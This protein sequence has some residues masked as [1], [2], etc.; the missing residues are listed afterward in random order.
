MYDLL[1]F[2]VWKPCVDDTKIE[3]LRKLEQLIENEP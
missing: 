3:K 1:E 2:T